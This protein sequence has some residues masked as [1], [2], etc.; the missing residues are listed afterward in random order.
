MTYDFHEQLTFLRQEL[1]PMNK[2]RVALIYG[3]RSTEHEISKLSTASIIEKID[4]SSYELSL[5][6]IDIDGQWWLLKELSIDVLDGAEKIRLDSYEEAVGCFSTQGKLLKAI[7]VFFPVL[8]GTY[9][10]DGTIQGL[11]RMLDVAFVGCDVLASA[12]CMDKDFTK[13]ILRD[14]GIGIAPYMM[15]N[16]L[17]QP[18]FEE[19]ERELG[20]PV[21]LKP[22]N[23]GSSVGVYKVDN[24]LDYEKRL[25]EG[26]TLDRKVL[27]EQEVIGREIECAVLGNESPKASMPGE[28]VMNSEFYDFE[29]KY[30]DSNASSTQIP[31][32]ISDSQIKTIRAQAVTAYSAI[33]CEGLARVDFFL[34]NDGRVMINEINTLPGFTKVSMYPKMWE[35]TGIAYN[36]LLNILIELALERQARYKAL[37]VFAKAVK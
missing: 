8:H 35:A 30:V 10:E 1:I 6:K 22:A 12:N 17:H 25:A 28:I 19:V 14:A 9:G 23:L 13:R 4:Q 37:K 18:S 11:F 3:G 5:I 20:M 32:D 2:T 16:L 7:D 29:S 24:K 31:A 21:F 33:G 15:A 36:E 27:I 26:L 34:A